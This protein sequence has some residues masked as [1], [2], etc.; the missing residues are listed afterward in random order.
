MKTVRYIIALIN[1]VATK[2]LIQEITYIQ[3]RE[4]AKLVNR[5]DKYGKLGKS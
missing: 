3:A 1:Q 5:R 4:I 2:P